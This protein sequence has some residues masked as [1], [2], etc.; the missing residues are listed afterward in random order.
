M[1]TF[2]QSQTPDLARQ[3]HASITSRGLGKASGFGNDPE[4]DAIEAILAGIDFNGWS[5]LVGDIDAILADIA[6]DGARGAFV[7]IGIGTEAR[8]E[9]ANIV[10]ALSVQYG[11]QRA[12]AMVGMRVDALGSVIPN[13]RAHWQITEG[14]RDYLRAN[15]R[16]AIAEGLSVDDLAGKLRDAYGFSRE[17]AE[18]IARTETIAASNAGALE[19]YRASGVVGGKQWLTAEDDRVSEDCAANG[20]AGT[21]AIDAAFPSGASAPPDHPNCRCTIVPVVDWT[22]VDNLTPELTEQ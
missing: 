6:Q 5:V 7:Q 15:V 20:E 21:V 14:T 1:H 22:K 4:L 10:N 2:L 18:V 19:S 3:I 17:R 11:E 13:P 16:E 9:V 8:R 12:A